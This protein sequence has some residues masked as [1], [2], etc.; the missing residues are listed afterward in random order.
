MDDDDAYKLIMAW[1]PAYQ[2]DPDVAHMVR[3]QLL[4]G[5][6]SPEHAIGALVLVMRIK[7]I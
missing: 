3:E 7:A 1:M 2:A 5:R 6:I 4:A